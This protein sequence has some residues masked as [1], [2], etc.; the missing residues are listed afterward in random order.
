MVDKN[1]NSDKLQNFLQVID[2]EALQTRWRGNIKNMAFFS[3]VEIHNLQSNSS[4]FDGFNWLRVMKGD[5]TRIEGDIDNAIILDQ[6]KKKL[7]AWMVQPG[8][9]LYLNT[10]YAQME[11]LILMYQTTYQGALD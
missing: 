1:T 6:K 5:W 7:L 10:L 2:L 9:R 4:E 8:N 11:N 3:V